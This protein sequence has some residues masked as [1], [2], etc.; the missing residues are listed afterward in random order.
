MNLQKFLKALTRRLYKNPPII[1][2]YAAVNVIFPLDNDPSV[3]LIEKSN[4]IGDFWRG[5]IAFPGGRRMEYEF[6]PIETALRESCEEIGIYRDDISVLG[7]L[8]PVISL[9][10]FHV[11]VIPVVSILKRRGNIVFNINPYEV[12]RVF[13]VP[14]SKLQ[15]TYSFIDKAMIYTEAYQAPNVIDKP[16]WGITKRILDMILKIYRELLRKEHI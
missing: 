4:R 8:K 6:N 15:Y 1:D 9:F 5:D 3:I 7:V 11:T 13:L 14:L 2:Y 12:S 10:K 16:I